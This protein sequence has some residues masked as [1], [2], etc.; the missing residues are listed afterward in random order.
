[1]SNKTDLVALPTPTPEDLLRLGSYDSKL[2]LRALVE[3]AIVRRLVTGLIGAG[4]NLSVDSGGDEPDVE[5]S[6]LVTEIMAACFAV[7]EASIHVYLDGGKFTGSISLVFGNSGW[8]VISDYHVRLEPLLQGA[9]EYSEQ[10][11]EWF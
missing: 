11:S 1:M 5:H 9:L 3:M 10:L 7:D 2:R 4:R 8:D 6:T